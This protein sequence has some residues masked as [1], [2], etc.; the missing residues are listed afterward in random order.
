ME[1]TAPKKK[2]WIRI[3]FILKE[4]GPMHPEQIQF[5]FNHVWANRSRSSREVAQIIV[6]YQ[7]KGFQRQKDHQ[8]NDRKLKIYSFESNMPKISR[9]TLKRWKENI[10]PL[11]GWN[12]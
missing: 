10:N 2:D 8:L 11:R 9:N 6:C 1:S 7:N 3:A 4:L 5:I 12:I